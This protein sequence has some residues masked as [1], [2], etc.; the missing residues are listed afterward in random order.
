MNTTRI[1]RK[2]GLPSTIIDVEKDSISPENKHA[3]IENQKQSKLNL[4]ATFQTEINELVNAD[5]ELQKKR[6]VKEMQ[7]Q[8]AIRIKKLDSE[9][10]ERTQLLDQQ[11]SAIRVLIETATNRLQ[12]DVSNNISQLDGILIEIVMESLYKILGEKDVYEKSVTKVVRTLITKQLASKKVSMKVSEETFNLLSRLYKDDS[13]LS[14]IH[15]DNTLSVGQ[16]RI[17]DGVSIVATGLT[18]QLDS[19]KNTLLV[20][21]REIHE[22]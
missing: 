4:Q 21:L 9:Y 12:D 20:Q 7:E 5:I 3:I 13:I 19:L 17:D 14:R 18:D 16:I 11:L 8:Y 1:S 6:L 10:L 2:L 15:Q 22:L